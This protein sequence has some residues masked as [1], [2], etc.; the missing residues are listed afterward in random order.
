MRQSRLTA[1]ATLSQKMSDKSIFSIGVAWAEKPEYLGEVD[2]ELSANLGLRW[3]FYGP[4][5]SKKKRGGDSSNAGDEN[6]DS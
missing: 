2:E 5:D 3:S 6:N 1:T 4:D